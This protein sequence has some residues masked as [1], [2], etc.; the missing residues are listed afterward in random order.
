MQRDIYDA[1]CSLCILVGF[2][3][4]GPKLGVEAAGSGAR[5]HFGHVHGGSAAWSECR[6]PGGS[7]EWQCLRPFKDLGGCLSRLGQQEKHFGSSLTE[8]I[9][10]HF[11]SAATIPCVAKACCKVTLPDIQQTHM[12]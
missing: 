10:V 9:K 8:S 11:V 12:H 3:N 4:V 2:F 1:P 7:A 5:L 6:Q